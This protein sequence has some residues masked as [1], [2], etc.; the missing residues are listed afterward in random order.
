MIV[1][2]YWPNGNKDMEK[3]IVN[4]QLHNPDGPARVWWYKS[5][6][7]CA[8][9]YRVNGRQHNLNGPAYR[10]WYESGKLFREAYYVDDEP[11]NLNGP[12]TRLLHES[13]TILQE[14]YY[15]GGCQYTPGQFA[16]LLAKIAAVNTV[17]LAIHYPIR[18]HIQHHYQAW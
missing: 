10:E 3:H 7:L 13:G 6:E 14:E 8:E 4:G 17:L 12:A 2:T 11:H 1:T 5:G 16:I 18:M 15:I 9:N